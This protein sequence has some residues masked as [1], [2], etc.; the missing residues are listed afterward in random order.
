[1]EYVESLINENILKI[2]A[3]VKRDKKR[4]SDLKKKREML[5]KNMGR[6]VKKDRFVIGKIK[7]SNIYVDLLIKITEKW[8]ESMEEEDRDFDCLRENRSLLRREKNI[9][10]SV[11]EKIKE[12]TSQKTFARKST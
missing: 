2:K 4:L 9:L 11:Q 7:R 6:I 10:S 3:N 12:L 1:M 8:M 5:Y